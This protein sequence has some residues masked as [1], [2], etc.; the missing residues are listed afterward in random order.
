MF[1]CVSEN[2]KIGKEIEKRKREREGEEIKEIER[3]CVGMC[4]RIETKEKRKRDRD[5]EIKKERQSVCV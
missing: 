5:R 3:E 1:V 2:R 4:P